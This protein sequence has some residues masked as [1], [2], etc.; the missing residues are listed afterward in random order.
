MEYPVGEWQSHEELA[1]L[2]HR[3][4]LDDE[5]RTHKVDRLEREMGFGAKGSQTLLD[6]VYPLLSEAH[7]DLLFEGLLRAAEPAWNY[8]TVD[9]D[10]AHALAIERLRRAGVQRVLAERYATTLVDRRRS[11]FDGDVRTFEIVEI[12]GGK[13]LGVSVLTRAPAGVLRRLR[14]TEATL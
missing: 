9:P 14:R 7:D 3:L 6:L 13:E 1:R 10:L 12:R 8:A 2:R 5:G 4:G 11:L